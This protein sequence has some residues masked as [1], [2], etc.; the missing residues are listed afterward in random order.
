MGSKA[1]TL[2]GTAVPKRLGAT[3]VDLEVPIIG[4][5]PIGL[6]GDVDTVRFIYYQ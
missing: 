1:G 2:E 5:T 6:G 4:I 3:N